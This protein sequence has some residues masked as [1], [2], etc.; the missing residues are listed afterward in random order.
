MAYGYSRYHQ[1][2][3]EA[4]KV[5]ELRKGGQLRD[6]YSLAK[7]Y[8]SQGCREDSFMQAYT[9]V[10]YDCLKRYYD[11]GTRFFGDIRAYC[12]TLAQIRKFPTSPSRDEMFIENL[13]RHVLRV[14]WGLRKENKI[15]DLQALSNEV[16]LWRSGSPLFTPDV[17]RMLLVGLKQYEHSS[18]VLKWLGVA[19]V[20][21]AAIFSGQAS[22]QV[23]NEAANNALAWAL[24]D[25]LKRFAGDDQGNKPDTG[26][27]VY[28]LSAIRTLINPPALNSHEAVDLAVGKL[29]H[30]GWNCRERKDLN[31]IESLLS[32]AIKWGPSSAMHRKEVLTM[33]FV[34]LKD[35]PL[36]IMALIEWYG[37]EGLEADRKSVV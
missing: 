25:E 35:R 31:Q 21:W 30:A 26:G 18:V 13:E 28:T 23:T 29:V 7:S 32:E 11:S 17:A 1:S 8:Y 27:L 10:M 19:N 22:A 34:S 9:W 16:C 36:D 33:F 14:G 37:I 4:Y 24:Y 15:G 6:A 20:P 5:T 12:M 3:D 2:S